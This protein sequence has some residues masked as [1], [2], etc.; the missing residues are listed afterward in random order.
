[1]IIIAGLARP[2]VAALSR[3]R[4]PLRLFGRGFI[5]LPFRFALDLMRPCPRAGPCG[6][7]PGVPRH[8]RATPT[9]FGTRHAQ[10]ADGAT[11]GG[12]RPVAAARIATKN[13]LP[14]GLRGLL[15]CVIQFR[16]APGALRRDSTLSRFVTAWDRGPRGRV[17]TPPRCSVWEW[18]CQITLLLRRPS[19]TASLV[20][21]TCGT[22]DSASLV[23]S[24]LLC[25]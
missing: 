19:G 1:V 7:G 25:K 14:P 3:G 5:F 13:F 17:A 20:V 22:E 10:S 23:C 9:G 8:R 24:K 18:V 6:D 4:R 11:D 2:S 12:G 16:C 21:S 15:L